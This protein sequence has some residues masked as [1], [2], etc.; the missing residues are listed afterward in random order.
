MRELITAEIIQ[1]GNVLYFLKTTKTPLHKATRLIVFGG[2]ISSVE[3]VWGA[4]CSLLRSVKSTSRPAEL[5]T[6]HG[7]HAM[8]RP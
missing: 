6:Y 7:D 4:K 3:V 8:R 1:V 2:T 5:V